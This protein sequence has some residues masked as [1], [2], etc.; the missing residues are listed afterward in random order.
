MLLPTG[1]E[2]NWWRVDPLKG[3]VLGMS[4]LGGSETIEEITLLE[5]L[6]EMFAGYVFANGIIG[7]T[8]HCAGAGSGAF[9]YCCLT[10]MTLSNVG[11]GLVGKGLSNYVT[12]SFSATYALIS[13]ITFDIATGVVPVAGDLINDGA[14]TICGAA[15]ER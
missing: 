14:A 13:G 12:N 4:V 9:E 7:G 6:A 8:Q 10:G 2:R 5:V 3:V 1:T 11:V 15:F